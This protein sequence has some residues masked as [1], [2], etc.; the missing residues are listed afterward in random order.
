MKYLFVFALL[1]FVPTEALGHGGGLNKDGCHN[2]RKTG[3]YHCHRSPAVSGPAV[4][5]SKN[6]I[7]HARGSTYY[8]RTFDYASYGS[9]KA[10]LEA[11]GRPPK[12]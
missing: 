12:R 11:G 5:L 2:N 8:D 6:G 1:M 4:K 7:C 10:C 3:D 9:M